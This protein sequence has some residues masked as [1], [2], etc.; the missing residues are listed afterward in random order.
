MSQFSAAITDIISAGGLL[1][2]ASAR[3]LKVNHNYLIISIIAIF[4]TW[5]TNIYQI[6][7]LASRAFALYYSIQAIK[8]IIVAYKN[9]NNLMS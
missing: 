1:S 7:T 5:I 9:A 4:L 6:I 2:E 8:A 3:R